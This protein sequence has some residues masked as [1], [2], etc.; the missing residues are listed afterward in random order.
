MRHRR[1]RAFR[2]ARRVQ[3]VTA[4]L[5]RQ[6]WPDHLR[7]DLHRNARIGAA[8]RLDAG[9][10]PGLASP[11][12]GRPVLLDRASIE[13]NRVDGILRASRRD[14]AARRQSVSRRRGQLRQFRDPARGA[15]RSRAWI[16]SRGASA[17]PRL[18]ASRACCLDSRH[19]GA[20]FA[21]SRG[22]FP[23]RHRGESVRQQARRAG[24]G[25]HGDVQA[26]VPV[27]PSAQH[28]RRCDGAGRGSCSPSQG[29][30]RNTCQGRFREASMRC[31]IR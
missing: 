9:L 10:H 26:C 5:R 19:V 30:S 31:S 8:G 7:R 6:Q 13:P 16:P 17:P 25:R 2:D 14:A 22:A 29:S 11:G 3:A 18:V 21:L 20:W 4:D 1:A 28:R 23:P 15:V 27:P 12:R 24:C